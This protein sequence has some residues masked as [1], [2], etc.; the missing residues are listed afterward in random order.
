MNINEM[1][2]KKIKNFSFSIIFLKNFK[3]K[4]KR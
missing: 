2:N 1:K 4:R 3:D